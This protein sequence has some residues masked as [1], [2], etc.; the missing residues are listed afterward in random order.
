MQDL[1]ALHNILASDTND[2]KLLTGGSERTIG[3]LQE[4]AHIN[5]ENTQS[6]MFVGLGMRRGDCL[7]CQQSSV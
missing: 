1:W 3:S 7:R 2:Q 4:D 5:S 6:Y